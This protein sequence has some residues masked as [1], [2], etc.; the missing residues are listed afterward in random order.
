[1]VN[2]KEFFINDL[3]ALGLRMEGNELSTSMVTSS[4]SGG[5]VSCSKREIRVS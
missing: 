1:M 4:V 5:T 2:G 3:Q